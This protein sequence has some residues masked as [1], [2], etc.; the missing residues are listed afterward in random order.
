[1]PGATTS[2][3]AAIVSAASSFTVPISTM[4]P[5]RI[6]TSAWR[7]GAPVPSTTEPP[8]IT[9]SSIGRTPSEIE[10]VSFCR[11][12]LARTSPRTTNPLETAHPYRSRSHAGSLGTG[13]F[14]GVEGFS[15]GGL[16][17]GAGGALVRR[18]G[19]ALGLLGLA[20]LEH[21]GPLGVVVLL[22]WDL[23]HE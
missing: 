5:A 23:G 3:P 17:G 15:A 4:R 16:G 6:P 8:L 14:R 9:Q 10:R 20:L 18:G 22:A 1:M 21:A 2:P 11:P 12:E 7:A 13:A 19:A